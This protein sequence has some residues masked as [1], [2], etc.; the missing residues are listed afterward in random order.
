ML[1]KLQG[2]GNN[3]IGSKKTVSMSG[4][5][6]SFSATQPNTNRKQ[7]SNLKRPA[8]GQASKTPSTPIF[9]PIKSAIG[10]DLS[11]LPSSALAAAIFSA[12]LTNR[13]VASRGN[14]RKGSPS[15]PVRGRKK[16][17]QPD[18]SSY[19][20][21]LYFERTSSYLLVT[22]DSVEE[23]LANE[24]IVCPD[25][26]IRKPSLCF[27]CTRAILSFLIPSIRNS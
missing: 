11:S 9:P 14:S 1:Q 16:A 8:S 7:K 17:V 27:H 3:R 13:N 18:K 10:A 12:S 2:S 20:L 6:H 26:A 4:T 22:F 23:K 25:L 15:N 24:K 21:R 19:H 5:T